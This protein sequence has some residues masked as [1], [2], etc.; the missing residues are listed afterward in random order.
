MSDPGIIG[1]NPISDEVYD[2][3]F[4]DDIADEEN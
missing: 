3:S 4:D 2:E 1:S